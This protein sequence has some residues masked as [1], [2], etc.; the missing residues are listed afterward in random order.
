MTYLTNMI[1][2]TRL[3]V[4]ASFNLGAQT[5][6]MKVPIAQ[7]IDMT[8]VP[9]EGAVAPEEVAQRSLDRAH[10][11]K[12]AVY[13]LKGLI[14]AARNIRVAQGKDTMAF[15]AILAR[16]GGQSYFS[17]Q[18]LV[19]NI[20]ASLEDLSPVAQKNEVGDP[21]TVRV[22]FPPSVRMWVIDGQHRR[23][24][25]NLVIEFLR[26][27]V[28]LRAYPRKGSLYPVEAGNAGIGHEELE[29]WREA[30][31]L[32]LQY[33]TVTVE[34]H[35]GLDVEGQRQLF[36]D[37]NN[38]GKSVSAGMAFEF[39]NSN[40]INLFIKHELIDGGLLG[41]PV[42]EKDVVDWSNHDGSMARKDIVGVN[43]ILFLN[44]TN[45]K[46]AN[47]VQVE[48]MEGVAK[49]FWSAVSQIDGFGQPGAKMKTVAAQPVVLKALAK[50]TYD[51][52]AGKKA[53]GDQLIRLIEGIGEIDFSHRNPM[54]RYY[55][56]SRE[57]RA[58]LVPG[59][60]DYLPNDE[61]NRD[62]GGSD[63]AGRM[64]FGAKHNDIYPI[65]GDMI[66]WRLK[67]PSR[68]EA[69]DVVQDAA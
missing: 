36:H 61:G 37:L 64:R 66:R 5:L 3:D 59:L 10:A 67:L 44:K 48:R 22:S 33:C 41:A 51:F 35:L 49:D 56:L 12:L 9:N 28:A 53:D 55:E 50:L 38:L 6:T 30:Q 43:S 19:V 8:E 4:L 34:A 25:M 11:T 60:S 7:F 47:P 20:P 14:H 42:T 40:P 62:V 2:S 69:D 24:A 39:D 58:R 1:A 18:P 15:D 65:L 27:V 13:I 68:Q 54:W 63:E 32:A 21:L 52:G 16:L 57:E 29:V 26:S 17:L 23:W 45:P 46:G 31:T